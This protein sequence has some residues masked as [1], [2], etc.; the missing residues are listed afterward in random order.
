MNDGNFKEAIP[1][2]KGC[3]EYNQRWGQGWSALGDCY[4]KLESYEN[5]LKCYSNARKCGFESFTM[6]TNLIVIYLQKGEDAKAQD[7]LQRVNPEKYPAEE[8]VVFYELRD[9][10]HFDKERFTI[11]IPDG[12]PAPIGPITVGVAGTAPPKRVH[13]VM[14]K[15]PFEAKK[16]GREGNVFLQVTVDERGN[17]ID[18]AVVQG[19]PLG[20][21]ESAVEA[22]RQWKYEPST[23]LG[24]P[25][26]LSFNVI[27][28]FRLR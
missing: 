10:P 6:L 7:L 21:T 4:L 12:P 23:L 11:G 2:W 25:I 1:H 13:Y 20:M 17:V 8:R 26:K 5:A 28:Q 22:V 18:V 14:P 16:V 24:R 3:L 15:Y 19:G 27:V 9:N